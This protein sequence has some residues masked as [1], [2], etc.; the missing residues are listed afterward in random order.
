MGQHMRFGG[1]LGDP[2]PLLQANQVLQA[3]E[4]E[5]DAP[6]QQ[7]EG[8]HIGVGEGLG[9]ERGDEDREYFGGDHSYRD[10]PT[11]LPGRPTDIASRNQGCLAGRLGDNPTAN[12]RAANASSLD[13]PIDEPTRRRL[14]ELTMQIERLINRRGRA[15]ILPTGA[16]E[17]IGAHLSDCGYA[18]G[19]PIASIADADHPQQIDAL[20]DHARALEGFCAAGADHRHL[21]PA[22][23]TGEAL[24]IPAQKQFLGHPM[25]ESGEIPV[26]AAH[27]GAN[28][29]MSGVRLDLSR[30]STS[31]SVGKGGV[32]LNFS[33]RGAALT[34]GL[35]RSRLSCRLQLT[36]SRIVTLAPVAD[37]P[38]RLGFGPAIFAL[39]AAGVLLL[40]LQTARS[41][42]PESAHLALAQ[43]VSPIA[44]K[45]ATRLP[46]LALPTMK[47]PAVDQNAPIVETVQVAAPAQEHVTTRTTTN[48]RIRPG[49]AAPIARVVPARLILTVFRRNEEWIE[50]GGTDA[51]GWVHSSLI[52]PIGARGRRPD[53]REPGGSD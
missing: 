50:V 29:P 22:E 42:P 49:Q 9:R 16:R 33:N 12:G 11:L 13:P 53:D 48:I 45:P 7:M 37:G 34:V 30:S 41:S 25:S 38:A 15:R 14:A 24:P 2:G 21:I 36:S 35:P 31:V 32:T 8:E 18:F 46:Q 39:M 17:D 52:T 4:T 10:L 19:R 51:W 47:P 43:P 6:S 26:H 3:F 20:F 27:T 23:P 1:A 5:F 40:G 44:R 28:G